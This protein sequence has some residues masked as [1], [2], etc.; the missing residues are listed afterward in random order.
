MALLNSRGMR[1]SLLKLLLP[2]EKRFSSFYGRY[3]I[4]CLFTT[5]KPVCKYYYFIPQRREKG[6]QFCSPFA[7]SI[8]MDTLPFNPFNFAHSLCF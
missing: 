7:L 8:H 6:L 4:F 3:D 5:G 1:Y 2:K